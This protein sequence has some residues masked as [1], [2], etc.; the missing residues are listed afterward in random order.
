MTRW[1]IKRTKLTIN[2]AYIGVIDVSI[3]E[4]GDLTRAMH[5]YTA[6]MSGIHEQVQRCIVVEN[7]GF[8]YTES[9]LT[10]GVG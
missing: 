9:V 10:S 1:A 3:H 7:E 2:C 6:L 4:V 8:F 5:G